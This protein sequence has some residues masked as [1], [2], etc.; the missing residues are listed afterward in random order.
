MD[1]QRRQ[2][3]EYNGDEDNGEKICELYENI[4]RHF[5]KDLIKFTGTDPCSTQRL[6]KVTTTYKLKHIV[7]CL[8]TRSV[9]KYL[10]ECNNI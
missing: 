1:Q 9:T 8:N 6:A 10:N 4:V 2:I 5:Q 3:A 7:T